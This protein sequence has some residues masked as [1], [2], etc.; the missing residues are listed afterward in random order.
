MQDDPIDNYLDDLILQGAIEAV[1]IDGDS[2]ELLYNF[3]PK[4]MEVDNKLYT[5]M[6]NHFHDEIMSLWEKGF[7]SMDVTDKNPL[8]TLTP[9]AL[10]ILQLS[11]LDIDEQRRLNE[12][13]KKMME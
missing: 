7:I 12:I 3:T 8:V 13:V 5:K 6:M 10:D 9:K 2:G 4:L 11:E 1:G